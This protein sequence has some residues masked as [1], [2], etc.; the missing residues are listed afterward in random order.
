MTTHLAVEKSPDFRK[1]V[2]CD[3]TEGTDNAFSLDTSQVWLSPA[4]HL[5]VQ[6]GSS[7]SRERPV[8]LCVRLQT[9]G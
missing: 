2:L 9:E 5:L 8:S 3:V 6:E 4:A 1:R 7:L